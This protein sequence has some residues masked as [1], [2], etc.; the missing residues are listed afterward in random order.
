MP[1]VTLAGAAT[2]ATANVRGDNAG[3]MRQLAE[4]LLRDHGY[5]S[6]AY[7]GGYPDSPDN[8]ER[9]QAN[10]RRG[11]SGTRGDAGQRP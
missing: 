4:H 3:G 9:H 6:L 8:I 1:V 11:G 5:R 2:S 10:R 7:L